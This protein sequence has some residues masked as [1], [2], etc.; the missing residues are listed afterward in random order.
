MDLSCNCLSGSLLGKWPSQ[1]QV[2]DL[3]TNCIN[4][5]V[6]DELSTLMQLLQLD[7]TVNQLS[8][9]LPDAWA[10][11]NAFPELLTLYINSNNITGSL[12]SRW[13]SQLA[14]QKL[15][16]LYLYQNPLD[17]TLPDS[18][19]SEGAF[20]QLQLLSAHS[21]MIGGT[22]P[23]SWVSQV[24]FPS[25]QLLTFS[26]ARL[27]GSLPA[28]HNMQLQ[29][30]ELLDN[31]FNSSL[32]TFWNSSAPL[33]T[34]YLA[35][36][37]L[38]STVPEMSGGLS[39]LIFLDL[40]GNQLQGTV[41]LSWMQKGNM[42]SHISFLNMGEVWDRSMASTSWRQQ[43][44][45]QKDLYDVDVTGQQVA[46]LPSLQQ[47]LFTVSS[48]T[49][50]TY[51]GLYNISGA[52]AGYRAWSR[53]NLNAVQLG[54]GLAT[55]N[56]NQLTSVQ[57]ICSNN[58]AHQT[59]LIVW[60]VF[61][62]SCLFVVTG[63]VCACVFAKKDRS[64]RLT[65]VACPL[66]V[67][68]AASTLYDAFKGFGGLA[69]YCYDLVTSIIVLTQVWGLWP[70]DILAAIFFFHFAITGIVVSFHALCRLAA[71]RF[72]HG[73]LSK[74]TIVAIFAASLTLSP[75][76]ISVVILLD[77]V[78][79]IAQLV[80][81]LGYVVRLP[82]LTWLGSGYVAAVHV[83]RCIQT[84]DMFGLGWVDLENYENMHNLVAA[85]FQ[86]LPTVI[87]NSVLFSLGNKPSHG[88]FLSNKL[89][90]A[91]IVASCLAM[92]RCLIIVEQNICIQV[93][94]QLVYW[95]QSGVQQ[96]TTTVGDTT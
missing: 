91:A 38:T 21:T 81:V 42:L 80:K 23:A 66:W 64:H 63:Y 32:D 56:D 37:S 44:C 15:A 49:S 51:S 70:G 36:N 25:M 2:L 14:F 5:S 77:T 71:R 33:T 16:W 87:L 54:F 13:G 72:G 17:G 11:P 40:S 68:T 86:S 93:C 22:L 89:F 10:A 9:Q 78:A 7:L 75:S 82:K 65:F 39:Q 19:A 73:N 94:F 74:G 58:D 18:W 83:N 4:G 12:P 1:L 6:P 79:F 96:G 57:H 55:S 28:I 67:W 76:M 85:V 20:P 84:R 95:L 92:L 34:V 48:S 29:D 45:L 53:S 61:G 52:L 27:E 90:V 30:I 59:L 8:G 41:P 43:L 24:A 60:L 35:D 50:D 62:G 46:L 26:S 3:D 88:I 69:F 47:S 31:F